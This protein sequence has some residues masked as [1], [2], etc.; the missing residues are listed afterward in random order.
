MLLSTK[1]DPV[2]KKQSYKKD[3]FIAYDT[4]YIKIVLTL[5]TKIVVLYMQTF[6]IQV[7][8]PSFE[9]FFKSNK[10]CWSIFIAFN[11]KF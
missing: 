9:S 3:V 6:I 7:G 10:I 4:G 1:V 2:L 5:M 11:K 8:I